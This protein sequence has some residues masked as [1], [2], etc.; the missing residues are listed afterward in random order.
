MGIKEM[1]C[2]LCRFLHKDQPFMGS[3]TEESKPQSPSSQLITT[4]ETQPG[5]TTTLTPISTSTSTTGFIS[6]AV[7][8]GSNSPI[9]RNRNRN[10]SIHLQH[11]LSNLVLQQRRRSMYD[12]RRTSV[13]YASSLSP[14][15]PSFSP[16]LA[17]YLTT[18]PSSP[19]TLASSTST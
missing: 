3:D 10:N 2:P 12:L 18:L 5:I 17:S 6:A 19:P 11:N 15:S 14:A 13:S 8:D 9:S 16:P 1:I 7:N 4:T